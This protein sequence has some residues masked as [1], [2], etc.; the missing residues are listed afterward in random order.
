MLRVAREGTRLKVDAHCDGPLESLEWIV[1]GKVE[2]IGVDNQKKMPDGSYSFQMERDVSFD[3]TSWVAVRIWRSTKPGRWQFAHSAPEWFDVPG[4]PII[5]SEGERQY[6][7]DRMQAEL[8]RSR[9]L[10]TDE[11][12]SEYQEALERY[13][14]LEAKP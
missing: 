2:K 8:K 11:S 14:N 13:R 1:N 3:K 10:L 4:K 9:A 7:I 12:V 6:L 5:P